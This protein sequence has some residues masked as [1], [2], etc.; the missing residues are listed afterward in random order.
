M[1]ELGATSKLSAH[2]TGLGYNSSENSSFQLWMAV[3]H[4]GRSVV[5]YVAPA[6]QLVLKPYEGS[7]KWRL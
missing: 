5:M 2:C 1:A 3:K 4:K 7:A 6:V